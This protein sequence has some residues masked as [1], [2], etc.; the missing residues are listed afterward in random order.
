M[1]GA[2]PPH[3]IPEHDNWGI[4]NNILMYHK[5]HGL[6]CKRNLNDGHLCGPFGGFSESSVHQ[7]TW[8]FKP[9]DL[10]TYLLEYLESI[11]FDRP[12]PEYNFNDFLGEHRGKWIGQEYVIYELNGCERTSIQTS[13]YHIY[14]PFPLEF[15]EKRMLGLCGKHEPIW[16]VTLRLNLNEETV[17]VDDVEPLDRSVI[18]T[19]MD[20]ILQSL[21]AREEDEE[22]AFKWIKF[23]VI[24]HPI[25][26][27]N[28]D[29]IN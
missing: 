19:M 6:L 17:Y 3:T 20:L 11:E 13:S 28:S 1:G 14:I 24:D 18:E 25:L 2:I 22:D 27:E 21:D 29:E 15:I 4:E 26:R 12:P 23:R 9:L 16:C 7:T 10:L 5:D 8:N